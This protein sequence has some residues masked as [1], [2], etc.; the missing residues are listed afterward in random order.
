MLGLTALARRLLVPYPILLVLGGLALG[1]V[2]GLTPL[3]LA[4]ELV[5][6]V[7]LPPILWAAAYFSSLRDL[8]ANIR[9]IGLLAFGLVLTTTFAVAAVA[10]LLMPGI[11]WAEAL[12]LGAIVSPPDAVAAT[13]IGRRLAI[14]RR[15]VAIL[16]GESLVNDASALVIYR[17]AVG[18]AVTGVFVLGDALADFVYAGLVGV[19]IGLLVGYLARRAM[20]AL[21]D[22]FVEIAITLLSPYIAWV[23]AEQVHASAVLACVAGGLYIRRYYSAVAAPATRI[24]ARAVWDQLIFLLNGFI[25]IL[26]G[27]QLGV[28]H[29]TLPPGRA[30]PVLGWAVAV[31]LTAIVVRLIWVPVGTWLP[32]RL[33]RRIR[34]TDPAPRPKAVFLVAWIG[35]RGIVSLAAA[36]ALP[37]ETSAG[38]PFPYRTE[39]VLITFGV[40]LATLVAQGLSLAPLVRWLGFTPEE[41]HL[42]EEAQ[43]RE[44]ASAA[45][46]AALAALEGE[47]WV[48][49]GHVDRMRVFYHER[50]RRTSAIGGDD[51]ERSAAEAAAYRRL[52][53]QT[54]TAERRALV[55]LRNRGEIGDET[56]HRLEHELDVEA[57]RI[58]IGELR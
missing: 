50:Q 31:S 58:G 48:H 33:S 52:R 38:T 7:F 9:P 2:P 47:G 30:T 56:L 21:E 10:R 11:G 41:D 42:V 8:R 20:A 14:P 32:R 28:L 35:M 1:F 26:I 54:L 46:L 22:S 3:V 29:D 17:A 12:A 4:P 27:L 43:A 36:M 6:L 15:V 34:E 39:I 44:Q 45:A 19:A 40:I 24:Q 13:A 55:D 51:R 57:L 16:E 5:F 25:F 37:F 18:A 49:G 53:H 23:A